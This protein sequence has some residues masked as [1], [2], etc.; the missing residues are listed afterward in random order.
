[1]T[2][3]SN[4]ECSHCQDELRRALETAACRHG[5]A[6]ISAGAL[7]RCGFNWSESDLQGDTPLIVATKRG[8]CRAVQA[9]LDSGTSNPNSANQDG[10]T[11]LHY[12]SKNGNIT[13]VDLLIRSGCKTNTADGFGFTPIMLA[14]RQ[15]H[16]L[17]VERLIKAGCDVNLANDLGETA[18]MYAAKDRSFR[19]TDNCA[20]L[21]LEA[22]ADINYVSQN[23]WTALLIAVVFK[24]LN[25]A[26]MLLGCDH[27]SLDTPGTLALVV[28]SRNVEMTVTPLEAAFLVGNLETCEMLTAAGSD[29]N[30]LFKHIADVNDLK[31][32]SMP[33]P[34]IPVWFEHDVIRRPRSL[35]DLSRMTFRRHH[36]GH[37]E[38]AVEVLPLP[39]LLKTYLRIPEISLKEKH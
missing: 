12:A 16:T 28:N 22:G 31:G 29:T 14:C 4:E 8:L 32:R 39:S 23:G 27:C 11:A 26:R 25:I 33:N 34:K 2:S 1:M 10:R 17:V 6:A 20:K 37:V 19:C 9:L 35:R 5:N 36:K 30:V 24:K 38:K 21:L 7:L 13:V 3:Q 18:L 15:G